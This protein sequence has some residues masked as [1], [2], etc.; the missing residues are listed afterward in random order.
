MNQSLLGIHS[1]HED[2][3]LDFKGTCSAPVSED[4]GELSCF[5]G[6]A[7]INAGEGAWEGIETLLPYD[8]YEVILSLDKD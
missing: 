3:T 7:I 5:S 1:T 4:Q 2:H 6:M 8:F